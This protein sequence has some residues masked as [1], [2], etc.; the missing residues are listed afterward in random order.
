MAR[1]KSICHYS[2]ALFLIFILFTCRYILVGVNCHL[3]HRWFKWKQELDFLHG[4]FNLVIFIT[5]RSMQV[6]LE[7]F[8]LTEADSR[9]SKM[10]V[11]ILLFR[12]N[13][14]QLHVLHSTAACYCLSRPRLALQQPNWRIEL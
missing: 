13:R 9:S 6:Q 10:T 12:L 14:L 2:I 3:F 4:Q 1:A 7:I 8:Q 11:H 5:T